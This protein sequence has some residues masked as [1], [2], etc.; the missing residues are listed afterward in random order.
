VP[1]YVSIDGVRLEFEWH[2][3]P[4]ASAATIVFLHEGLG[5]I[6]QWRDFPAELC[7]RLGC[8]GL[9]YSRCG[10]GKSD[11]LTGPR[12]LG[13]MHDE[14]TTVLPRLLD[15]FE[16]RRPVIVG[17]SDGAS[18]ALIHAGCGAGDPCALVLEAPHV[19]V[20]EVTVTRIAELR[21]LYRTGDLRTRLARY[22]GN[23]VDS[24]FQ[25]WTDVWLRPEFRDW[26]IEAYLPDVR[27]PTLVIQGKQ[28]EYGTDRQ[29]NALVAALGGRCEG[30]MLD[31]CGHS[32]HVDQR[33]TVA[34]IMAR[35]IRGLE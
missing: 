28:D 30:I 19:F 9:V 12:Q 27:C 18:I 26:N 29:V 14:A 24:L 33:A 10:H 16:V 17:H 6:G 11:A 32:P 31:H 2:G 34:D 5:S 20:E 13:F 21:E 22:H 3:P 15:V 4:P 7:A 23:N 1:E 8:G 25:Y 35:F